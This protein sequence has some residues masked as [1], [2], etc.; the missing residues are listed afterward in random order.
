MNTDQKQ[1]VGTCNCLPYLLTEGSSD[2]VKVN[3]I[4]VGS[5]CCLES[6]GNTSSVKGVVPGRVLFT[7]STSGG[8]N[9]TTTPTKNILTLWITTLLETIN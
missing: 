2:F 7:E 5:C 3:P 9:L 4:V 8:I 1:A 6:L